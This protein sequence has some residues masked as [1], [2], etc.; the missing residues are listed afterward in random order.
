MILVYRDAHFHTG[1]SSRPSMQTLDKRIS[2]SSDQL[3]TLRY[4]SMQTLDKR[5]SAS[6]DQLDTLRYT[7]MQTLDKRI[8]ASSDQRIA[9]SRSFDLSEMSE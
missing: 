1:S 4:T 3:D 6:S 2:A 8:S 7:S 9:H 5:I